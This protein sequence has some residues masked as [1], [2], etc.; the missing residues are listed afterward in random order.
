MSAPAPLRR[1]MIDCDGVLAD[2]AGHV[3]TL[4]GK[5]PDAFSVVEL[6]QHIDSVPDFYLTV[7]LMADARQLWQV[8]K[9]FHPIVLTGCPEG[10]FAEAARQKNIWVKRHFGSVE[11]ITCLSREKSRYLNAADDILIDDRGGN[12]K[13]WIKAGGIG[14]RHVDAATTI[15]EFQKIVA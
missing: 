12:I 9:P 13:K 11:V 8:V 14:I 2:F 5:H 7:P 6:W 4:F 1:V 15:H 10:N 3:Q